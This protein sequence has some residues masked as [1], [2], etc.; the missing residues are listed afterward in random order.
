[1]FAIKI[2]AVT[3]LTLR[4]YKTQQNFLDIEQTAAVPAAGRRHFRAGVHR[5]EKERTRGKSAKKY[6][7]KILRLSASTIV[8]R[9]M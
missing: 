1:M 2:H 3:Q 4:T 7:I 6:M 9:L 8:E 5:R